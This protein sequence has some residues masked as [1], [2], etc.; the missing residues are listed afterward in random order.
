MCKTGRTLLPFD[1]TLIWSHHEVEWVKELKLELLLQDHHMVQCFHFVPGW[2]CHNHLQLLWLCATV[3]VGVLSGERVSR[4]WG[5]TRRSR[6]NWRTWRPVWETAARKSSLVRDWERSKVTSLKEEGDNPER[7]FDFSEASGST[8]FSLCPY[9]ITPP[10][11]NVLHVPHVDATEEFN[12]TQ[13]PLSG[14]S[15][16]QLL[17]HNAVTSTDFEYDM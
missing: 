4:P 8:L 3:C 10:T 15:V 17:A 1:G 11:W 9:F 12:F 13:R 7:L 2:P 6:S 16:Q 5:T 14:V